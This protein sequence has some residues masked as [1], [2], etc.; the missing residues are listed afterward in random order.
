MV[1]C[2]VPLCF[3]DT[4]I[5]VVSHL[6]VRCAGYPQV[7]WV[8]MYTTWSVDHTF[9]RKNHEWS[10]LWVLRVSRKYLMYIV[11]TVLLCMLFR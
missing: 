9:S 7:T 11:V 10:C 4:V 5:S 6:L 1:D 8:V 2:I 3:T